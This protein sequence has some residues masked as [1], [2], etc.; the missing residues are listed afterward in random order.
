[1]ICCMLTGQKVCST[2]VWNVSSV[3]D[4]LCADRDRVHVQLGTGPSVKVI[5]SSRW[6][7]TTVWYSSIVQITRRCFNVNMVSYRFRDFQYYEDK[8]VR[9]SR[10]LT[11]L[12]SLLLTL[13]SVSQKHIYIIN[14]WW[15]MPHSICG[16]LCV[17]TYSYARNIWLVLWSAPPPPPPTL[18]TIHLC[19]LYPFMHSL[20]A[21]LRWPSSHSN[22]AWLA[23][24]S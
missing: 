1:M 9:G 22:V 5:L 21:N 11:R 24:R 16:L 17:I 3:K 6:S 2:W 10:Y 12:S 23:S 15:I 4:L 20:S 8:T 14:V 13:P 18:Y 19:I 7:H